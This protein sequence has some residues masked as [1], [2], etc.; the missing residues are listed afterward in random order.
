VN[1]RR[2][3]EMCHLENSSQAVQTLW[4]WCQRMERHCWVCCQTYL[5]HMAVQ[6]MQI[7][8]K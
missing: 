2:V 7:E 5:C 3:V 1:S 6:H 4:S 8:L